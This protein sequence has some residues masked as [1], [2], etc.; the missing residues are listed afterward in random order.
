MQ[1]KARCFFFF[2]FSADIHFF[3][4]IRHVYRSEWPARKAKPRFGATLV[5]SEHDCETRLYKLLSTY[6]GSNIV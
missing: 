6:N 2:F 3:H 5:R 1:N 4:T